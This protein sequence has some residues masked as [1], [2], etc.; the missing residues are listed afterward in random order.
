MKKKNLHLV[1]SSK[2]GDRKWII[3]GQRK[4]TLGDEKG[5]NFL[6]HEWMNLYFKIAIMRDKISVFPSWKKILVQ[7]CIFEK[8]KFTVFVL[9]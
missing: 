9:K 4:A 3:Y 2:K 1:V 7:S 8:I 6:G 5:S